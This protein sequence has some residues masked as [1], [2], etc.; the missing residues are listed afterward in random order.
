MLTTEYIEWK[1]IFNAIGHPSCIFDTD[2]N[3][4]S[5]NTASS[6]VL[7][8]SEDEVRGEKCYK[9]FHGIDEPIEGCPLKKM[10]VS[11]HFETMEV[12]IEALN[13]TFLVSCSPLYDKEGHLKEVIHIAT[14]ITERKRTEKA[15][16]KAVK[17][18]ETLNKD[19]ENKV[20]IR[21]QE[22]KRSQS[23]LIQTE[24]LSVIGQLAGG[25]S[26]ELN[27]PLAGLLP[28]IEKYRE[29]EEKSSEAY[30]EMTLMLEGCVHMAKIVKDFN[31]FS[32]A[33]ECGYTALN[34]NSMIDDTLSFSSKQFMHKG[35]EIIKE[36]ADNL[37]EIQGEKPKLQQVILNMITNAGDAMPDGGRLIIRTYVAE[38]KSKVAMEFIDNG[39]GITR[40]D[41]KKIFDPFFTTKEE[42]EKIGLG[43]S[44]SY[45]IIKE[46]GGDISVESE[47]GKGT[48]FTVFLP[49]AK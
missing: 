14:D 49:V 1:E 13:G 8:K 40:E 5:I 11:D 18:I 12:E 16:E 36:Y 43:L 42:K 21:T 46:H 17:T 20:E 37:P 25:L 4:M 27:S 31:L 34:L 29:K 41:T 33:S 26:H 44:V 32:E 6:K 47:P 19:L 39:C 7:N 3:I 24:K 35:N 45:G 2:F 28:L 38:D 23:Q 9:L 48:K 10:I 30:N 22:L 15:L